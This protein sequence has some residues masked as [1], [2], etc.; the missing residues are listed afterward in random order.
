MPTDRMYRNIVIFIVNVMATDL[1][2]S[3]HA[4]DTTRV[5]RSV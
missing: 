1:L 2:A 5:L 3:K 4:Q